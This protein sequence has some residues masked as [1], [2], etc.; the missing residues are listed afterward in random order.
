MVSEEVEDEILAL[1]SI[2]EQQFSR[3]GDN[4]VRAIVSP[5][6]GGEGASTPQGASLL[7]IEAEL[8]DSYPSETIPEFSLSNIN[9]NHFSIHTREDILRG[10][11]EQANEQLGT[12]SL[13]TVIEWARERLPEWLAADVAAQANS[14]HDSP[15]RAEPAEAPAAKAA[16][17]E[18][19]N[20][21]G[22]SKGQKRRH[23]DRFGVAAE[24][25]RGHEWV[26]IVSHL[27]KK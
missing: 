11:Q 25:P 20:I 27:S 21:R 26:D 16:D 6:D 15:A 12:C 2:Y 8:P 5:E 1:E 19:F 10:L 22:M 13:Y 3:I 18:A 4:Q 17:E 9:N 14:A 23:F 7:Y 24:K